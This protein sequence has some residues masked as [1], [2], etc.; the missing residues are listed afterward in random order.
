MGILIQCRSVV[1]AGGNYQADVLL[2][3]ERIAEAAATI[4]PVG[5]TLV[6]ATGSLVMPGGIS[7]GSAVDLWPPADPLR[8]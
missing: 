1:N 4:A 2:E 8:G 5:L 3:G 7:G 6:D